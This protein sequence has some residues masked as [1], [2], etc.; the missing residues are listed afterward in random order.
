MTAIPLRGSAEY[1][2][3]PLLGEPFHFVTPIRINAIL[4]IICYSL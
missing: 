2:R 3:N 1:F 4:K